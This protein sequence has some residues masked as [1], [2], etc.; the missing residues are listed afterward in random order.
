MSAGA[1]QCLGIGY[2]ALPR[3]RRSS[4]T[5]RHRGKCRI[6]CV[7]PTRTCQSQ[8]DVAGPEKKHK[9]YR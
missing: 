5:R 6:C 7:K 1:G 2:D 8:T 3:S 9:S 4:P